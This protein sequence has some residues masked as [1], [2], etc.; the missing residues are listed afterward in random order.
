[1]KHVLL[2]DYNFILQTILIKTNVAEKAT[3]KMLQLMLK[4]L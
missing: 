1:M 3:V 2:I 4:R